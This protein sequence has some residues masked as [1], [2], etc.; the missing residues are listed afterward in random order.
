MRSRPATIAADRR[1][2]D[3]AL[4]SSTRFRNPA[5]PRCT[6][7]FR[8]HEKLKLFGVRSSF[9]GTVYRTST[10]LG[11]LWTYLGSTKM[12]LLAGKPLAV[13]C[14][15]FKVA[16]RS[17]LMLGLVEHPA[18]DQKSERRFLVFG[19]VPDSFSH[20]RLRVGDRLV[21]LRVSADGAF[22]L[23]AQEPIVVVHSRS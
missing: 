13:T 11:P 18:A 16:G 6:D 22:A 19:V 4:G 17:G 12:C 5:E 3:A 10:H 8:D 1:D 9:G 20:V 14:A 15:P 23:R 2:H 21:R 7:Y